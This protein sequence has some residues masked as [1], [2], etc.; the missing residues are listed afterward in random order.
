ML[1]LHC[2]CCVGLL[3]FQFWLFVIKL[4]AN[5][6]NVTISFQTAKAS[7]ASGG[8]ST[9]DPLTRDN[10]P[11]SHWEHSPRPPLDSRC[12]ACHIF[13]DP[14]TFSTLTTPLIS[15][16]FNPVYIV[17]FDEQTCLGLRAYAPMHDFR[18]CTPSALKSSVFCV[19]CN[20][21][22][23]FHYRNCKNRPAFWSS[24]Q[25][26]PQPGAVYPWTPLRT[27]VPQT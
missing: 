7:S 10:T 17:L 13:L 21:S 3:L 24:P 23:E 15:S 18:P 1:C 12:R 19:F 25:T 2:N 6:R 8:R 11:G 14:F 16:D 20:I 5:Y 22:L 26:P 27:S 9:L 4:H